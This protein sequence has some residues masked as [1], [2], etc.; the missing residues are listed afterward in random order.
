M[1]FYVANKVFLVN[2]R[3][4]ILVVREGTGDDEN[5]NVGKWDVPGGRMEPG[6][7]PIDALRREV[8]E[9]VGIEVAGT[10]PFHVRDWRPV[11]KGEPSQIVGI[12]H[13]ASVGDVEPRLSKEHD[14]FKWLSPTEANPDEL[15]G[16][17]FETI[18]VWLKQL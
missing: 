10:R 2:T 17:L 1:K 6:E 13:V 7:S 9:E 3:G 14:E 12:Y 15:I 18:Q 8:K 16:G 4:Q 11:I 5:T